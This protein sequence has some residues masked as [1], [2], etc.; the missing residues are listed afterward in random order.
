VGQIDF[1]LSAVELVVAGDDAESQVMQL[2]QGTQQV[3]TGVG[4]QA[5]GVDGAGGLRG[6]P[7]AGGGAGRGLQQEVLQL[8]TEN[9]AQ[10]VVLP[11]RQDGAQQGAR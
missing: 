6:A 8:R 3:V 2:A 7:P 1:E 11:S 10:P 9:R 4:A 5:G